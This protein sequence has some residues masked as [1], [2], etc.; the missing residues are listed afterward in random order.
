MK[1]KDVFAWSY[2]ELKGIPRKVCE[3]KIDLMVNAQLIKQ[4][5]KMNPNYAFKVREDL[6]KLLNIEFIYIIETIQRLSPL[7]I[8]PKKNGKLFICVD[9]WK[10]K[11]QTKKDPFMLPFLDSIFHS[12]VR[13]KMYSFMDGYSNYNQAKMAKENKEKTTFN[14]KWVAYAYN[15]MPFGLCNAPATFQKVVTKAFKEYLNKFMQVFLDDF[16][17]YGS[18]R[19]HL[20]QLQSCLE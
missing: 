1:Y 5:V 18:K 16:N 6:D 3:H 8:V 14:F 20:G 13:H 9:Y 19:D 4:K 12:M 15:V 17:V 2:K 10:L 11:T 7:V